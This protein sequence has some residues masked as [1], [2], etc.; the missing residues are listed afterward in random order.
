[1]VYERKE[2]RC[3]QVK[4]GPLSSILKFIQI[5]VLNVIE[6]K[7]KIFTFEDNNKLRK[8]RRKLFVKCKD[9]IFCLYIW[10]IVRIYSIFSYIV[11]CW[12]G[13]YSLF[14]DINLC[15][16]FNAK[17][18][19]VDEKLLFIAGRMIYVFL[20]GICQKVNAIVLVEFELAY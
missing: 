16:L 11:I 14:N 18:I 8:K 15:G 1:M 2:E 13:F 4:W 7:L 17:T 3:P 10:H 20:M 12:F 9:Q 5:L 6:E 19:L